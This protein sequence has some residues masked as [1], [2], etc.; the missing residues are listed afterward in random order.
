MFDAL[1]SRHF[2]PLSVKIFPDDS[3]AV[4]EFKLKPTF[5]IPLFSLKMPFESL[6]SILFAPSR[7]LFDPLLHLILEISLHFGLDF[8]MSFLKLHFK[9]S[10]QKGYLS[11]VG[12]LKLLG[13]TLFNG[14]T[15]LLF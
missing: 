13:Y 4:L 7:H 1:Q 3:D 6:I 10:L 15:K 9:L 14:P 2:C 12:F 5:K 11:H 8:L